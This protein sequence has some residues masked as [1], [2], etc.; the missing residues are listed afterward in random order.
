V[1]GDLVKAEAATLDALG[2]VLRRE[3]EAFDDAVQNAVS[4]AIR[5][6]EVLIEAKSRA[7]HGEWLPWLEANF[8]G[9]PRSAQGYM[10]LAANSE[11]AR[12]VAHLGVRGALKYSAARGENGRA[13]A[14]AAKL[15][16]PAQQVDQMTILDLDLSDEI[17][18]LVRGWLETPS[19]EP[20]LDHD[21][22]ADECLAK[23]EEHYRAYERHR[24]AA[25]RQRRNGTDVTEG[26]P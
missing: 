24:R 15:L 20:D 1:S 18:E 5:V 9:S 4:H 2:D 7:R 8:P 10:Q 25:E 17:R 12:R 19:P 14:L 11:D 22:L 26:S 13:E 3:W 23:A 21:A 6:G 16:P